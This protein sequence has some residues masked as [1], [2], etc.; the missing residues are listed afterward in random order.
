MRRKKNVKRWERKKYGG[1]LE[2]WEQMNVHTGER[3][4]ESFDSNREGKVRL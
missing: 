4:R 3:P 2:I 1:D